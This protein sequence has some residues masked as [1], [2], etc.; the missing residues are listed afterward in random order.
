MVSAT[1][2][3]DWQVAYSKAYQFPY[4]LSKSDTI[5]F[6][7]PLLGGAQVRV[8]Y[9]GDYP[10]YISAEKI[11]SD[12]TTLY[13]GVD[14]TFKVPAGGL[15]R[16]MI[17]AR[18]TKWSKITCTETLYVHT[19]PPTTTMKY[20]GTSQ[21]DT[22]SMEVVFKLDVPKKVTHFRLE[23]PAFCSDAVVVYA[24]E[25]QTE[26]FWDEAQLVDESDRTYEVAEGVGMRISAIRLRLYDAPGVSCPINFYARLKP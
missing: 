17:Y 23:V 25:T 26:G 8:E 24:A 1:S 7:S 2:F 5:Y 21:L 11:V 3:A 4:G 22:H 12:G 18:S 14:G 15:A 16:A 6:T 10:C 19:A 9:T 20:L 13:P